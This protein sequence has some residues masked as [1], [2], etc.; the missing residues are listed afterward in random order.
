MMGQLESCSKWDCLN[1]MLVFLA[2]AGTKWQAVI[3]LSALVP[4]VQ[5]LCSIS[6]EK[7]FL[8]VPQNWTEI[9]GINWRQKQERILPVYRQILPERPGILPGS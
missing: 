5:E 1:S 4:V 6:C 9:K 8:D 3:L 7:K 2:C